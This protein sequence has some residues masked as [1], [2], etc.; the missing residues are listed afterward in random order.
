MRLK[1]YTALLLSLLCPTLA[2]AES[3]KYTTKFT[4]ANKYPIVTGMTSSTTYTIIT[5]LLNINYEV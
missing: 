1:L 3:E 5:D 4:S 2:S